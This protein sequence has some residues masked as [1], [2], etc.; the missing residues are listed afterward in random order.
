MTI[1]SVT[2]KTSDYLFSPALLKEFKGQVPDGIRIRPLKTSDYHDGFLE[3]LAQLTSV[4]QIS[5]DDFLSRFETMRTKPQSYYV[6]VLENLNTEKVVGAATLVVEWKFIHE[7]GCRGR[8]EDVVV[9]SSMRGKKLG[10]LLNEILVDLA[11]KLEV[12]KLSLE[13]KDSLIT[14]YEQFGYK[15][16]AGNNFLVQRFDGDLKA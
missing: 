9:D 13:C 10:V 12:Y 3:V 15:K 5:E 16:D 14:F 7:A 6:V 2:P 4:G 11:K 1:A 8:V